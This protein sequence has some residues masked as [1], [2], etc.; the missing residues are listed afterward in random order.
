[1]FPEIKEKSKR[2]K[3]GKF[4]AINKTAQRDTNPSPFN[5]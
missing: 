1:M 2:E 3:G 4:Q 5:L